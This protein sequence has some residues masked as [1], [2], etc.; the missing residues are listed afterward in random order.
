MRP[1]S[2]DILQAL[3]NA[4]SPSGYEQPAA[5]VYREYT[6]GF[7]DRVTTDV[8]GNVI[9]VLNPDAPIRIM[10]AGHMD[11][12]GFLIHFIGEDGLLHFGG[13]GG[14]DEVTPVGQRVWVHGKEPVP[15]VVGSPAFHLLDAAEQ[16]KRPEIKNLWIDIGAT[17]RDEAEA[18]VRL[19]DPVTFQHES[20]HC[21]VIGR[22]REASIT[23]PASSLPRKRSGCCE[24]AAVY[25][26]RSASTP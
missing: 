1:A 20:N 8:S 11:E 25:T 24:K 12:I 18:L 16:S 9:A 21:K 4:P 2:L 3:A 26:P 13:I 5:R 17:S 22:R 23:R 15:G 7:A 6:Q 10:L 19:G 14:H